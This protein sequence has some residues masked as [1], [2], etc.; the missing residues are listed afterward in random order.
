MGT[1]HHLY[2]LP[3]ARQ[4]REGRA[5]DIE[6]FV[7]GRI[8]SESFGSYRRGSTVFDDLRYV[9]RSTVAEAPF[10]IHSGAT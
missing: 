2:F 4:N 6:S 10:A 1:H 7:R 3:C 8:Y 5:L 9:K